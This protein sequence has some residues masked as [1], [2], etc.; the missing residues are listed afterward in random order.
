MNLPLSIFALLAGSALLVFALRWKNKN[1][2]AGRGVA[3]WT[4][5]LLIILCCSVIDNAESAE[6]NDPLNLSCE[7]WGIAPSLNQSGW[8]KTQNRLRDVKLTIDENG[9]H[10][11]GALLDKTW[12]KYNGSVTDWNI[13]ILFGPVGNTYHKIYINTLTAS[14]WFYIN[15]EEDKG[16]DNEPDYK[17]RCEQILE[18]NTK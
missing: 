9:V 10:I 14:G 12:G 7:V 13:I 16:D 3:A 6:L 2:E 17:V 15:F 18:E 1:K 8:W 5:V 4:I 11:T